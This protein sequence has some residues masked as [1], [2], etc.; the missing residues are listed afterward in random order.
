MAIDTVALR[1][2]LAG[3]YATLCTYASL[4]TGDPAG[5]G[6]NE[7]TG[8]SPAYARKALTWVA[9]ASDGGYAANAVTF[10]VPAA[11]NITHVGLWDA[12]TAGTYRDKRAFAISF[13]SQGTLTITITYAQT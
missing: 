3:Q 13:A 6:A 9:G 4:H 5:T 12:A 2:S 11:T 10:D 7:V 8:G 1:E